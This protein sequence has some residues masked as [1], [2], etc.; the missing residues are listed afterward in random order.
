MIDQLIFS[1]EVADAL[2]EHRP[3]VALESTVIAHGLPWPE[4]LDIARRIEQAVRDAGAI[5]AT[6]GI[7]DGAVTVGLDADAMERFARSDGIAKVSRRDIAAVAASGG[8][9]ATTVAG[10]MILADRAGIRC[11]A[12]GGIGGVHRGAETTFDV[13]AD[14]SELARTSVLVVASGAKS[15]LDLPKTLEVLETNGV[16]V[17][18][19]G[20][21][22]LPAFHA[23]DS[24]LPI[25]WRCDTP[26]AVA[27][28]AE[29][30]WAF[31]LGG[32]LVGNPVPEEAAVG[33]AEMER[34]VSEAVEAASRDGVTGKEVTPY[35]LAALAERSGGW[36]LEAN[37][38]LLIDNARVA[39]QI[40]V[41]LTE[42]GG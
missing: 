12:T 11:F 2:S 36:S 14:L 24:G 27:A 33:S 32:I 9:G 34:W 19:Y 15:I 35:L 21:D 42:S 10:T 17:L 40:A 8:C 13:S 30:H 22:T 37:K 20:T 16:P 23:R 28:I 26:A 7:V 18:G 29:R 41:A 38:A 25:D 4:N 31:G 3:V 6:T 5:P 1:S 39:A